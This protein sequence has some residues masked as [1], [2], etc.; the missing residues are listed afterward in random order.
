[1]SY[2]QDIDAREAQTPEQNAQIELETRQQEAKWFLDST[3]WVV[4]KISEAQIVGDDI[5]GLLT[6]YSDVLTQRKEA[7]LII[8][9]A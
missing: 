9:S 6:Q 8:N 4:V 5:S 1:M 7:R 3:D 2:Q